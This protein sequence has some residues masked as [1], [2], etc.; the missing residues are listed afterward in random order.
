MFLDETSGSVLLANNQVLVRML[1]DSLSSS[2]FNGLLRF[3][4]LVI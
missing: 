4:V 3:G 2:G 1:N